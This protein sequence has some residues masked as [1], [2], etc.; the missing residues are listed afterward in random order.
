MIAQAKL[1]LRD[2]EGGQP[3]LAERSPVLKPFQIRPWFTEK[4]HL[5]LL[6]LT[7]T[8]CKVARRNFISER[9]PDLADAERDLLSGS[10]LNILEVDEDS[11]GCLRTQID[12]ILRILRH[13]LECL[14]HQVELADVCEI[15]LAAGRARD[16]VVIDE[17][18]HLRL[19]HC[20]HTLLK[21]D[22]FFFAEILDQLIR[23][24]T[25]VAFLAVHQRIRETAKMT[26]RHPGLGIHQNRTVD[27]NV[28]LALLDELS[29]P[30]SL[31]IVFELNPE[32][33]VIPGVCQSAVNLRAR[34]NKAS[35]FCQCN[36]FV[37]RLFH[38]LVLLIV[39]FIIPGNP[40][41]KPFR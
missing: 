24:E 5:H 34:I 26:G 6:K 3:V 29:P 10:P 7:G 4:L 41:K 17:L 31:D 28:V 11:L 36:D 13:T 23:A 12:R 30:G 25:L 37:H 1:V 35:V 14:E 2:S 21:R 39:G 16:I 40:E 15:V 27:T 20:V 33:S 32:V 8:E 19:A 22:A 18:L 9:L 38:R